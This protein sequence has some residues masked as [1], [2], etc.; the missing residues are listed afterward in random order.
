MI[1][2]TYKGGDTMET[3]G[4][5]IRKLRENRGWTQEQLL[6]KVGGNNINTISRIE[7]GVTRTIRIGTAEKFAKAFNVTPEY[8]MFGEGISRNNFSDE[9]YDYLMDPANRA[10]IEI[11]VK[12]QQIERLR[13]QMEEE[14]N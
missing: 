3:A 10:A 11:F 13:R 12:Q 6:K 8:I 2:L 9:T 1:Q 7:T 4:D 5:R 14:Q